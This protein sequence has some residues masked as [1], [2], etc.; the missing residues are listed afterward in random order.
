MNSS[1]C[2]QLELLK[3]SVQQI[4]ESEPY[5]Q[6]LKVMARFPSYSIRNTMLIYAQNP[7]ATFVAGYQTWHRLFGRS[8]KKGEKGIRILAP[9]TYAKEVKDE[10]GKVHIEKKIRFRSIPVF[11]VSQTQG[12]ALPEL[13]KPALLQGE[14]TLL[15]QKKPILEELTH[16]QIIYSPL[17]QGH[18]GMCQYEEKQ[19]LINQDLEERH[20]FKTM[21]HE[22]AHALL[23]RFDQKLLSPYEELLISRKDLREIEAESVSYVV[24][25]TLGVECSDY[26]F[27]YVARWKQQEE[28]LEESLER[29]AKISQLMVSA[30]LAPDQE[31]WLFPTDFSPK[32]QLAL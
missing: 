9:Y 18:Y 7:Q 24:C 26:S 2:M 1:I 10:Q 4:C 29:I 21:V 15:K 20:A 32:Y 16:F 14:C 6:Y 11:D 28:F 17:P 3:E 30:L 13:P 19:I 22:C 12:R 31:T 8:V 25:T 23:H 27:S 5:K